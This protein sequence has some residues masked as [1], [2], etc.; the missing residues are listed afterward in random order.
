V[1][2]YRLHPKK[3]LQARDG[4]KGGR[5]GRASCKP[6]AGRFPAPTGIFI[7]KVPEP[8][9][10]SPRLLIEP[11]MFRPPGRGRHKTPAGR[12]RFPHRRRHPE[13]GAGYQST[14]K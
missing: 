11:T 6:G 4:F 14:I 1:A 3:N 5:R 2:T 8:P 9:A 7:A 12:N 13:T 10:G